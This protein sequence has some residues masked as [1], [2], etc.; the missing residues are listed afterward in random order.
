MRV[1]IRARAKLEDLH[2][3]V[4]SKLQCLQYTL[5]FILKFHLFNMLVGNA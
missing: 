3:N 5:A 4:H 1:Q 2:L